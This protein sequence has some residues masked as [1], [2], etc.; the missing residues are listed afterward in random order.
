MLMILSHIVVLP[1]SF[2]WINDKKKTATKRPEIECYCYFVSYGAYLSNTAHQLS[3]FQV[4]LDKITFLFKKNFI[5]TFCPFSVSVFQSYRI[6]PELL[7]RFHVTDRYGLQ[8]L[9]PSLLRAAG[10]LA[11][12]PAHSDLQKV[13]AFMVLILINMVVLGSQILLFFSILHI[14][15]T[16]FHLKTSFL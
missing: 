4:Y 9:L 14:Y 15:L 12:V 2:I 10:K 11:H 16:K 6:L 3:I 5:H 1:C 7:Q 13:I 8:C